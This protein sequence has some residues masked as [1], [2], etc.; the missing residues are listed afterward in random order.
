MSRRTP[1]HDVHVALG[2]SLADF[3]GWSM[4]IRYGSDVAE[5]HAIRTAAGLFDLTPMGEIELS[6]PEAAAALDHA[7][8][9]HPSKI[10]PG[11]ARYSML[12]DENGC[13]LDDL[14]VYRLAAEHF[15]LVVN[16]SNVT[17]AHDALKARSAAFEAD[18]RD[19]SGDW[20]L[21]AV[22]G[23]AAVAT[24]A[25]L[26]ELDVSALKYYSIAEAVLHGAGV[27]LARTG[28]T[29]EDGFEVY[30]RPD[31]VLDVWAALTA[32]GQQSASLL[33]ALAARD[34]LRLEAGMPLY[35]HELSREVTPFEAGWAAWWPSTSRPGSS[36]S[37]R[38]RQGT[39]RVP[40]ACCAVSSRP[41]PA[42][43]AR[44]TTSSTPQRAELW[45]T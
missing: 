37:Q 30:C 39:V 29:G 35:G 9:G 26:T 3:A 20:A 36:V 13:I 25:Q 44:G 14:V 17:V 32:A 38:W 42:P 28:Y 18:V 22:Q 16:A 43:L 21:V 41:G 24:V 15:L 11:R 19:T 45:G 27:L 10:A 6:G 5:H 1:L 33:R 8:V 34:T 4:P 12:C 40:T 31:D 2:A 23:P 7:L